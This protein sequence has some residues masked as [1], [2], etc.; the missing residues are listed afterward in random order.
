MEADLADDKFI[1]CAIKSEAAAIVSGDK[2]LMGLGEFAGIPILSPAAFISYLE[3][4]E[5]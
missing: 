5:A 1:E 4:S 2:H 3:N